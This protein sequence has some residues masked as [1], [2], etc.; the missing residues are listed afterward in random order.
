M[1]FLCSILILFHVPDLFSTTH[2]QTK[3]ARVSAISIPYL[4]VLLLN[5]SYVVCL[6]L[7]LVS[8]KKGLS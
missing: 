7:L 8:F 1:R 6:L 2:K 5:E 4:G 3:F